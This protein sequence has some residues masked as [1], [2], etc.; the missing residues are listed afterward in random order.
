MIPPKRARDDHLMDLFVQH[1]F[2]P[3][4]LRVLNE[5]RL[6]LHA[7]TV[8]DV[9]EAD[10]Q[11]ISQEAWTGKRTQRYN[12]NWPNTSAPNVVP[13]PLAEGDSH[14]CELASLYAIILLGNTVCKTHNILTGSAT[15]ACDN[16]QAISMIDARY[17]PD[18]QDPN[19]DLTSAIWRLLQQ[20]PIQ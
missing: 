13:G 12:H 7:T 1:D 4:R 20:S 16:K 2:E 11:A 9:T 10:G 15:I 18:P 17:V 3:T 5:C 8:A 14:R 6:H 19:F